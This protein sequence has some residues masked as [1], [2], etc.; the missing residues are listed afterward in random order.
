VID[1]L[2]ARLQRVQTVVARATLEPLLVRIGVFGVL[3]L[4]MTVAVP[5]ELLVTRYGLPL[6]LVAAIP[7]FA[8]R[9][10]ATTLAMIGIVAA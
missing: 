10:A 3:V 5:F 6:L 7:A 1:A 9:G 4:A 2:T 8:P